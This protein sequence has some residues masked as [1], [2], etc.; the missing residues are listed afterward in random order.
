MTALRPARRIEGL[1][2]TLLRTF[3]AGAPDDAVSLGLGQV[4]AD[5]SP[6]VRAALAQADA[7]TRA[8]YGPTAGDPALRR[9]IAATYGVDPDAVLVTC[10]VQEA[11]A[12]ALLGLVNPGDEVVV[13]R[14]AFPVYETLTRIAGGVVRGWD[15][16]PNDRMRPTLAGLQ[17]AVTDATQL[18]V[19]AS[20]GNPTGAAARPAEWARIGAWLEDRG[21]PWLSDEIYV[22]LQGAGGHPSMRAH[23]T[24]GLVT[25]GLSKTHALAGWR[26][27][28]LIVPEAVRTPLTALHQH[29]VTSAPSLTQQAS[30]AAFG[31]EGAAEVDAL[32]ATLDRRRARAIAGLEACGFEVLSGD[33]GLFVWMRAPEGD[34]DELALATEILHDARVIL[35]P[36]RAFGPAGRGHL[37]ASIGVRD[38][39]LD[40]ALRRLAGFARSRGWRSRSS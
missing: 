38:D 33:A 16:S 3:L 36:G 32:V 15:L 9:A 14:P 39:D 40:E 19:L 8:P 24:G 25:A 34:D 30:L 28:W 20:P 10:G 29:L 26:L 13:P 37:R 11:L 23:G 18:V 7:A 6:V 31:D 1:G 12:V 35:I 17:A 4:D 27:G 5:V 21:I 22:P 2:I